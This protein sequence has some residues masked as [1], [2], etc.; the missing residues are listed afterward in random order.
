M[1][2]ACIYFPI[3][4]VGGIASETRAYSLAARQAGDTFDVIRCPN[5]VQMKQPG[6]YSSPKLLRGGDTYISVDGECSHHPRHVGKSIRWLEKNYDAL[7][8]IH[9]C[10]HPTKAYGQD[11]LWMKMYEACSLPMAVKFMD[12]YVSTYKWIIPA[13][14]YCTAVY[15]NQPAYQKSLE[16]VGITNSVLRPKP[17]FP[18]PQRFEKDSERLVIWPN[19]WKDI[20]GIKPF[21]EQVPELAKTSKVELYSNGI[22]YYQIKKDDPDL[23]DRC[24]SFDYFKDE[25]GSSGL[26]E[27]FGYVTPAEMERVYQ[28]A[29]CSVNLQGL[30]S[31]V[32]HS[33]YRE[34][35]Y[36]NTEVEALYWGV[37]PVVARQV[38]KSPIPSECLIMVDDAAKLPEL[39]ETA[40]D[41]PMAGSHEGKIAREW[42]LDIHG[43]G[44]LWAEIVEDLRE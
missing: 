20:K 33:F 24:I 38:E 11:P 12:A 6:L 14:D 32:K 42:V 43:A 10:P 40:V 15:V 31:R 25:K 1:K 44:K 35:S 4:S 39:I 36:N 30:S 19:Q 17:F 5:S 22:R 21:M 8:F 9:P 3:S 28:R 7:F 13:L 37:W 27:F 41:Q 18:G 23:W 2:V 26:A 29:W 16:A 34:G